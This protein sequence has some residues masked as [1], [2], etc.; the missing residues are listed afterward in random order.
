MCVIIYIQKNIYYNNVLNNVLSL[1]IILIIF[2]KYNL[3]SLYNVTSMH[4]MA[5]YLVLN[6]QIFAHLP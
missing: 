4:F 3:L 5:D 1:I 2:S 6:N